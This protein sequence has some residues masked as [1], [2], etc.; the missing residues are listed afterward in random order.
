MSELKNYHSLY[1]YFLDHVKKNTNSPWSSKFFEIAKPLK[2]FKKVLSHNPYFY[3]TYCI[4]NLVIPVGAEIH[5]NA[6]KLQTSG[7]KTVKKLR[8]S[9]AVC[10]SLVDINSRK[11]ELSAISAADRN[12]FYRPSNLL[13]DA[14]I[15][16]RIEEKA[17]VALKKNKLLEYSV[18]FLTPRNKFSKHSGE[19]ESGIHFFLTLDEAL[20]YDFT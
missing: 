14:V 20:D 7:F 16:E 10:H 11:N 15:A 19:C 4:A 9:S 5:V 17:L 2:V 18:S 3:D 6:W 13:A 8:S 12:F 1:E